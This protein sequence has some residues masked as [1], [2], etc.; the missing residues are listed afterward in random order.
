MRDYL[1]AFGILKIKVF[2]RDGG[3]VHS[4]DE[5]VIGQVEAGYSLAH[6]WRLGLVPEQVRHTEGV[7]YV[8]P[9]C[10]QAAAAF[11]RLLEAGTIAPQETTVLVLT[12]TGLKATPRIAQLL[13]V[14]S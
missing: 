13:G 5:R 12:G 14:S 3:L 9:T 1:A 6:S 11:A 2:D 4:T 10:T 7:A 8:E